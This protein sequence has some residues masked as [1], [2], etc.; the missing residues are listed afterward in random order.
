[1]QRCMGGEGEKGGTIGGDKRERGDR[2]ESA[3]DRNR[4]MKFC[5]IIQRGG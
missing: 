2:G 5:R 1:M 3:E 4:M